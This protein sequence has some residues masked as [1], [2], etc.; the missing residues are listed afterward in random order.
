MPVIEDQPNNILF[1]HLWQL[2]R[3]DVLQ[4]HQP[5]ARLVTSVVCHDLERNA[6][7]IFVDF[8]L[9]DIFTL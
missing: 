4:I 2:P 8:G 1:R 7:Q 3:E 5:N 9:L 6:Y